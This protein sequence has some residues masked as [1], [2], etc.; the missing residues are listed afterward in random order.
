[1]K[2]TIRIGLLLIAIAATALSGFTGS[3][4]PQA[5]SYCDAPKVQSIPSGYQFID[6][7]TCS[8]QEYEI[9][10]HPDVAAFIRRPSN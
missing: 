4:A 3:S 7:E 1:M 10:R 2:T 6:Y 8:G 9:W 5:F